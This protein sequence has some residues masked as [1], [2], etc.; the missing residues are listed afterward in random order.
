MIKDKINKVVKE[1]KKGKFITL[2]DRYGQGKLV[3][4]IDYVTPKQINFL[5]THARGLVSVGLEN[6]RAKDLNLDLQE[7]E[8]NENHYLPYTVSV[9]V[10]G[11][12]TGI[13][14]F[15]RHETIKALI[16]PERRAEDFQK[17]GHVFPII[18]HANGI[19]GKQSHIEAGIDLAKLS[20]SYPA[21]VLCDVLNDKGDIANVKELESFSE[22]FQFEMLKVDHFLKYRL[23]YHPFLEEK[24]SS[25][26][27]NRL[28]KFTLINFSNSMDK[29][30]DSTL[31]HQP[32]RSDKSIAVY[33]HKPCKL[34]ELKLCDCQINLEAALLKISSEG[35]VCVYLKNRDIQDRDINDMGLDYTPFILP[36]MLKKLNITNINVLNDFPLDQNILKENKIFLSESLI[37]VKKIQQNVV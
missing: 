26:I 11:T 21:V 27:N 16:D 32:I 3:C 36:Q 28:G 35:G 7:A 4:L 37:N 30:S 14:S 29:Y 34:C 19:Y 31:L 13:S 12:T 15:E 10:V 23:I 24:K 20:D 8:Y 5:I 1:L 25:K 9:D 18:A 6:K 2:V 22:F 17:P 33:V